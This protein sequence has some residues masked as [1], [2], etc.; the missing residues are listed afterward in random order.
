MCARTHTYLD[1]ICA[2]ALS[3]TWAEHMCSEEAREVGGEARQ[4]EHLHG[5]PIPGRVRVVPAV[6]RNACRDLK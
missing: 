4:S 3:R 2:R 6:V 5:R 1:R